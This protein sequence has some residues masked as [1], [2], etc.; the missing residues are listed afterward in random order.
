M[1]RELG[2]CIPEEASETEEFTPRRDKI[3]SSFLL[4]TNVLIVCFSGKNYIREETKKSH[5][6]PFTTTAGSDEEA[7]EPS[8]QMEKRRTQ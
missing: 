6:V 2:G 4:K 5:Y 3:V 7:R 1:L 8:G